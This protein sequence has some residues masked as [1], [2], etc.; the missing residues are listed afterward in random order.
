[1]W[2]VE[3]ESVDCGMRN[4]GKLWNCGMENCGLWNGK[5]WIVEC[6][7]VENCGIAEWRIVDCGMGKCGL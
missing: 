6:V 7:I 1:L 3:W 2:I 5:V 4:C